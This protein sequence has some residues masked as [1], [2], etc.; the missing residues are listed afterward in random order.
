M[1]KGQYSRDNGCIGYSGGFAV[2]PSQKEG[3]IAL[4]RLIKNGYK[5]SSIESMVKHYAPPKDKNNDSRL[6]GGPI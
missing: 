2:F 1:R 4:E 3:E 6:N 5:N